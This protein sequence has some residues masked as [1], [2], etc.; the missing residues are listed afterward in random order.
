VL[1]VVGGWCSSGYEDARRWSHGK[2]V[3]VA[4]RHVRGFVVVLF[5][6]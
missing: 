3:V 2:V 6:A 1:V 4:L 5:V